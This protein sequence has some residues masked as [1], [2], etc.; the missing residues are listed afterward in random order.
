MF[1]S[2]KPRASN[3][4]QRTGLK[5][6]YEISC[7]WNESLRKTSISSNEAERLVEGWFWNE[8]VLFQK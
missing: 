7:I 5:Y 3:Q 2:I 8:S 1:E 4:S 6:R